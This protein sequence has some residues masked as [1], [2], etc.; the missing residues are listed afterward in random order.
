MIS[1]MTILLIKLLV[2][3]LILIL[4]LLEIVKLNA[5]CNIVYKPVLIVHSNNLMD[6]KLLLKSSSQIIVERKV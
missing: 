4:V 5:S 1:I 6:M 2:L 3:R